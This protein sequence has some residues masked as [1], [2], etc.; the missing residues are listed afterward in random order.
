MTR[1][2]P[3]TPTT[4]RHLDRALLTQ[5]WSDA[6]FLHWPLDPAVVAPLLPPG[7]EP[8][9]L[10]GATWVG[11]IGFRMQRLGLGGIGIPYVGWFPEINVRLYSRDAQ[12]RRGVVFR[13]L[14][15]SR[16]AAALGAHAAYQLPYCWAR[17]RID[18]DGDRIGYSSRRRALGP[19]PAPTDFAVRI[20]EPIDRPSALDLWL[21][22]RWGLHTEL[23]GRTVYIPNEHPQWRLH[24][25]EA[26]E[27]RDGLIASAGLPAPDA[28]PP[29]VLFSPGVP[30]RFGSPRPV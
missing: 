29:S 19:T 20:G 8:D 25:A 6:V 24:R 14:E 22:A 3:V 26:L 28:T 5:R 27:V 17:M 9:T 7:V 10:D 11:L 4:P 18:R 16:L 12:G 15:T 21:T 23:R 2:E 13:S 1:L 30:V